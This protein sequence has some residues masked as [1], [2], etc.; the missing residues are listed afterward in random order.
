MSKK[1][2]IVL[3]RNGAPDN[4]NSITFPR[5]V[6]MITKGKD[7]EEI[8]WF[9]RVCE[10]NRVDITENEYGIN[11]VKVREAF[12]KKFWPDAYKPRAKIVEETKL[13]YEMLKNMV[14]KETKP[15]KNDK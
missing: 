8:E 11:L 13:N 6:E 3:N 5:M 4:R 1:E 2:Q 14:N 12:I 15:T 10:A 9:V 7:R